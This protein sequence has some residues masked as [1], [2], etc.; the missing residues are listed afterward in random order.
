MAGETIAWHGPQPA[1]SAADETPMIDPPRIELVSEAASAPPVACGRVAVLAARGVGKA[2]EQAA[3][4]FLRLLGFELVRIGDE[5][6]GSPARVLDV[7]R[8]LAAVILLRGEQG[9][10][11][12]GGMPQSDARSAFELGYCAGRLGAGRV[13]VLHASGAV[14]CCDENGILHVPIDA[15]GGWQLQMARHFRRAGLDVDLNRLC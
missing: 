10:V 7:R 1:V 9:A 6:A 5:E 8:D 11:A 13:C 14:C 12:P 3:E 15:A 4:S 2:V